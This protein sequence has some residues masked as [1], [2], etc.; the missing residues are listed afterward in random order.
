MEQALAQNLHIHRNLQS[1][2]G[3]DEVARILVLILF[4]SRNSLTFGKDKH[5]Y[6]CAHSLVHFPFVKLS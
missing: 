4:A 5:A 2:A 3:Y 6:L 1:F